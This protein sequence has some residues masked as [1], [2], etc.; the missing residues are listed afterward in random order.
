MGSQR[1]II[2]THPETELVFLGEQ[3]FRRLDDPEAEAKGFSFGASQWEAIRQGVSSS[4]RS[5]DRRDRAA[6]ADVVMGEPTGQ[7]P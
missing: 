7:I 4:S 2:K 3:E 1:R 5:C 6:R